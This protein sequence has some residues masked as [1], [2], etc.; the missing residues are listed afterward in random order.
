MLH[1]RSIDPCNE[2]TFH[3]YFFFPRYLRRRSINSR[4]CSPI[5][6]LLFEAIGLSTWEL[7]R[8]LS[9]TTTRGSTL[10]RLR[11]SPAGYLVDPGI[12]RPDI[13]TLL[14]KSFFRKGSSLLFIVRKRSTEISFDSFA[15]EWRI[16]FTR[17]RF[18]SKIENRSCNLLTCNET[19][20]RSKI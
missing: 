14:W 10:R 13:C 19:R 16:L 18:S 1:A 15:G 2:S 20:T 11:D 17:Q 7:R 4:K 6:G 12:L 8:K 3:S 5:E 9:M